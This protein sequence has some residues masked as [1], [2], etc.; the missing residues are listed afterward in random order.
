MYPV[1]LGLWMVLVVGMA[2]CAKSHDAK[3]TMMYSKRARQ[4]F[5]TVLGMHS[6]KGKYEI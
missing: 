2:E 5:D 1:V 3:A 6:P 4:H